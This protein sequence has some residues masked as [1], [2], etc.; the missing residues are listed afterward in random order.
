M[1]RGSDYFWAGKEPGFV[2]LTELLTFLIDSDVVVVRIY[3]LLFSFG[4]ILVACRADRD[5]LFFLLAL[6]IPVQFYNYSMNAVRI[7]LASVFILMSMQ[8]FR[9]GETRSGFIL[10]VSSLLFH[11]YTII[12]IFYFLLSTGMLKIRKFGL[13]IFG[14]VL[15]LCCLFLLKADYFYDRFSAYSDYSP[16][17]NFSGLGSA[18]VLFLLLMSVW[19]SSLR[20]SSKVSFFIVSLGFISG[21]VILSRYTVAGL[22]VLDLLILI[23]PVTLLVLHSREL[24]TLNWQMKCFFLFSGL[25][26]AAAI[27]RN[28]MASA[29]QGRSP[30][31][32]YEWI[33]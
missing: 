15:L 1:S 16:P 28:F 14:F 12:S 7:G 9:R 13:L 11:Y 22:R 18:L 29:G 23:V 25:L 24:K 5:E 6:F 4:L 27:F 8:S 31:I 17:N 32:P 26:G 20:S 33:F 3:A 19:F 2:A 21:A 30:W 10:L